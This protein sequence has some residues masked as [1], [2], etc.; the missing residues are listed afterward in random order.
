MNQKN[1]QKNPPLQR[2]RCNLIPKMNNS[3]CFEYLVSELN[4][5]SDQCRLFNEEI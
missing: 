2:D 5:Q 4:I 1:Q 3:Y